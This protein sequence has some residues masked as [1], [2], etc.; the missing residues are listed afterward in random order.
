MSK[1]NEEKRKVRKHVDF[2]GKDVKISKLQ[3]HTLVYVSL[4]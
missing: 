1:W 4:L 3:L 2:I